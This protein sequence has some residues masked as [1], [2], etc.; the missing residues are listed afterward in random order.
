MRIIK[1]RQTGSQLC[2]RIDPEQDLVRELIAGGCN[3]RPKRNIEDIPIGVIGDAGSSHRFSPPVPKDLVSGHDKIVLGAAGSKA[4]TDHDDDRT[5]TGRQTFKVSVI[6]EHIGTDRVLKSSA[7]LNRLQHLAFAAQHFRMLF[8]D[9]VPAFIGQINFMAQLVFGRVQHRTRLI[10]KVNPAF[11]SDSFLLSR[12]RRGDISSSCKSLN[13]S[14]NCSGVFAMLREIINGGS[15]RV[16]AR[17]SSTVGYS[18]RHCSGISSIIW[19][20]S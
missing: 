20:S 15:L 4:E 19:D 18:C 2:L 7:S 6:E 1:N 11:Q 3:G 8:A 13:N 9:V 14:S 10:L 5:V 16:K 12:T 17:W